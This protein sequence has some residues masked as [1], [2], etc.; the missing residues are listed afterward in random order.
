MTLFSAAACTGCGRGNQ[1]SSDTGGQVGTGTGGAGGK[2]GESGAR[3]GAGGGATAGQSGADG[4]PDAGTDGGIST[5]CMTTTAKH[6]AQGGYYVNGNTVCTATG[7]PHLFHGVDRPSLE[8]SSTGEQLSAS[9]FQLQAGWDANV[10]RIAL[11]QDFWLSASPIADA[12]YP[13]TVDAAVKWAEEAGMD[14]ILDLHWSDTGTLGSCVSS[15]EQFMADTNSITFW[16]QVASIYKNDGRVLFE[17]YNEPHDV[18]WN[19]WKSGGMTSGGWIAVGMQQLYDAVRGAGADNLVVIGGLDFAF[20]LS[21]IPSYR[22]SGYNILYATHP[23]GGTAD[24]GPSGWNS[25]F[26]FLAATDPVVMTEFGDG[27]ECFEG[28]YTAAIDTYVSQL[29]AYA[30]QNRISWTAWAWYPG[31]CSFPSLIADWQ[32]TPTPPGM[33]VQASLQTYS[34]DPAPGGK[35]PRR[36]PSNDQLQW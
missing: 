7:N 13:T 20:D 1:T 32:G 10:V 14:V 19:V 33:L 26:G 9:D 29:L 15:C 12:N 16:S 3:G 5:G 24:E 25:A 34:N 28:T 2:A 4:G 22:I 21:G 27:A 30:D 31:G 17:L 23:Y 36:G 11:N 8:W 35:R 18:P 6:I